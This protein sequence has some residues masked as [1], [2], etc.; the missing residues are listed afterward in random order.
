MSRNTSRSVTTEAPRH[1]PSVWPCMSVTKAFSGEKIT[2][3]DTIDK[4]INKR[5]AS[6]LLRR[7]IELGL[8]QNQVAKSV[9]ISFQQYQKYEH[10]QNRVAAG[11]LYMI[12]EALDTNVEYFF[13][14]PDLEVS[15]SVSQ[16]ESVIDR[17]ESALLVRQFN[18]IPS[19]ELKQTVLNMLRALGPRK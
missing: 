14:G 12:A 19:Q 17:I 13:K 7:R 4:E 8:T 2:V 16:P 5:V 1:V 11:R 3:S 15:G 9:G 10:S 18:A 6:Q